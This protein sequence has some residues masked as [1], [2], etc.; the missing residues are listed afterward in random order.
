MAP[1]TTPQ[2]LELAKEL[3]EAK[4]RVTTETNLT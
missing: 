2:D 1:E 3:L 4:N